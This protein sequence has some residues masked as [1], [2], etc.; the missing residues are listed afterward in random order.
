MRFFLIAGEAS[1]DQL[2]A[3]LMQALRTHADIAFSGVGGARMVNAGLTSL[4]S[5]DDLAVMGF[6]PVLR[7]LPRLMRRLD[8]TVSAVLDQKPDV[9]ILIDS[10]DFTHRVA[11]R[12]RRKMPAL[13]VID[14]VSPT[15]WAWRSGRARAMRFYIDHVLALLPFEPEAYRRL[16]GPECSY[17]GHPLVERL[18]DLAPSAG[19]LERRNQDPPLIVALPGSRRHEVER[20]LPIFS[21]TLLLLKDKIGAFEAVL[22]TLP[23]LEEEIRNHVATWPVK[24]R[25]V[26]TEAEKYSA[27]RRARAGLAA[28]GTVT[29]ELA[30]AEV[31]QVVAYRVAPLESLARYFIEVPSIVLPNL[32]LG[33]NAIPEFLQ[34]RCTADS[35]AAALIG[36]VREGPARKA[37]IEAFD[38][39]AKSLALPLGETPSGRAA[40]VVFETMARKNARGK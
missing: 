12:V 2:G 6:L 19:D 17:V 31:P 8:E 28:S 5:L 9:L 35:L 10:P 38:A 14:Y 11:R 40:A 21:Q 13:P 4:F 30:L 15:V 32:I 29:L 26:A 22:A 24:P 1:G 20:L 3:G 33:R 25:L 37:Q 7:H 23:H 18:S 39:I 36:I 34:E 27:F 16:G